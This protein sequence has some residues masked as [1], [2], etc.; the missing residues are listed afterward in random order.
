MS[1]D[2][3]YPHRKDWRRPYYGKRSFDPAC[4]PHGGC[5]ACASARWWREAKRRPADEEEQ[6]QESLA[7][8]GTRRGFRQDRKRRD[9]G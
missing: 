1:F 5:P 2:N 3:P 7:L 4:R 6:I 8:V 9:K